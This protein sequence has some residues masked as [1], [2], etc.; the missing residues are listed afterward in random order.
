MNI[1]FTKIHKF[2]NL[3]KLI[4]NSSLLS[5]PSIIG[6]VLSLIAIPMH[7]KI[8][9]KYDYGN[10]IFFHFVVSFG[11]ILNLGLNK[12]ATIELAKKK[13]INLIINQSIKFSIITSIIF[14]F[15]GLLIINLVNSNFYIFLILV[16]ICL[17]VI[18]L[19]LEGILQGLK[20]FNIF[21]GVNFFFYTL[22]LNIPSVL[23]YLFDQFNYLDLIKISILIKI[24]VILTILFYLR[25]LKDKKRKQN[26]NLYSKIK[27]NSKWY[28]VH[29]INLQVFDF[30]DKYLIKILIGPIALA[31][32]SIP[33]QLAGKITIFSKSISAV[34]LPEIS[35]GKENTNFNYSLNIYTFLTPIF[36]LFLFALLEYLLKIWLDNQYTKEIL[37]LTK[38]FLISSWVSGISHI[39]IAFFEG[40]NKVKFNSVLEVYL[41]IPFIL[42]LTLILFQFKNLIFISF[43][44]LA[45]EM[46]LIFFRLNKI[47]NVIDNIIAIKINIFLVVLN[48]L[49]NIYNET[50]FYFSFLLLILTNFIIFLYRSKI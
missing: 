30:I 37:I 21:S 7:L 18:Y 5:L 50:Y 43:V 36:L 49:I 8:N 45:K 34:L 6:M 38:I 3:S 44:I 14:F 20:K 48:L 11:L 28:L 2:K 19:T 39:L 1:L 12:I 16:G 33:Y 15:I 29:F 31:I 27:K 17:T 26:Y 42:I 23:L 40:K 9:G 24:L 32:Y 47:R 10:Y 25:D 46:T 22:S 4:K 41:I 35:E 13:Y